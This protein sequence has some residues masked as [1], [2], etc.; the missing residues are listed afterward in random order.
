MSRKDIPGFD[1]FYQINSCGQVWSR[2]A[3]SSIRDKLGPWKVTKV[4]GLSR[5]GYPR[6]RL[7]IGGRR[8]YYLVHRLVLLTFVGPCPIGME[9]RHV[10]DPDRTN[11][12]LS[13]LKYGTRTQNHLDRNG[14]KTDVRG[15]NGWSAK[16]TWKQ[17][18]GIRRLH[19]TGKYTDKQLA[20]KFGVTHHNIYAIVKRKTWK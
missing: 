8:K 9:A 3:A 5:Y 7:T 2:R 18:R 1:G 17:V 16:L 10:P 4:N 19:L 12:Q 14:T 20:S 15:E 6:V 11:C 13:N